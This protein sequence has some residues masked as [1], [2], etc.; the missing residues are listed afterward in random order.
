MKSKNNDVGDLIMPFIETYQNFII[1]E[2][3]DLSDDPEGKRLPVIILNTY[4]LLVSTLP[5]NGVHA[6]K[7]FL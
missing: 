3:I 7:V 6:T 1:N 4:T 5:Y 2:E